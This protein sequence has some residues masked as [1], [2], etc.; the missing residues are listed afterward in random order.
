MSSIRAARPSS[1]LKRSLSIE[2][3][4]S[5]VL[6]PHSLPE[7]LHQWDHQSPRFSQPISREQFC[8]QS[9]P[10]TLLFP[11]L[12][13]VLIRSAFS[14]PTLP[15]RPIQLSISLRVRLPLVLPSSV[16]ALEVAYRR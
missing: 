10:L 13:P 2:Q 4:C 6:P 9:V 7:R 12:V 14:M 15:R 8:P 1:V 11:F 3:R 5:Q 16:P